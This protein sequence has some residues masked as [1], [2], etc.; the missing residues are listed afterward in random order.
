MIGINQVSKLLIAGVL[1]FASAIALV[2]MWPNQSDTVVVDNLDPNP[3]TNESREH[4]D[5][6]VQLGLDF[7]LS[8]A[9]AEE[10]AAMTDAII[11]STDANGGEIDQGSLDTIMADH[12]ERVVSTIESSFSSD[13]EFLP[14]NVLMHSLPSAAEAAEL[15]YVDKWQEV[16]GKMELS[17]QRAVKDIITEWEQFN[18]EIGRQLGAG[19]I[20]S[21]DYADSKLTIEELQDRLSPYLSSS[22]QVDIAVND[23]LFWEDVRLRMV[24]QQRILTDSGYMSG[25]VSAAADNDILEVRQLLRSGI[26]VN[27][28][29]TDGEWTPLREAAYAGNTEMA[30][31]LIDSGADVNWVSA[32]GVTALAEAA[33]SGNVDMV[34]LL[35]SEGATVDVSTLDD[36]A[37]FNRTEVV[38]EL[39]NQ[40]LDVAGE[41]GSSA[42]GWASDYGNTEMERILRDAGASRVP[43][44]L[45]Q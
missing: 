2:M 45:V 39:V 32:G 17:D 31:L 43:R 28:S 18:M 22:Q 3:A 26:D 44:E 20:S 38:R 14:N 15:R 7:G 35:L 41:A 24:E 33:E 10:V 23:E 13:Q 37:M 25:I 36:A 21:Q 8:Q 30:E 9:T 27:T 5:V 6:R 1:S 40:G 29:T 16:I 42:L 11:E 34:R 4:I 12:F 19:E